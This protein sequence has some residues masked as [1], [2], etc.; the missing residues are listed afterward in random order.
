MTDVFGLRVNNANGGGQIDSS[1][2]YVNIHTLEEGVGR[3]Y[4]RS[5]EI[6]GLDTSIHDHCINAKPDVAYLVE[7]LSELIENPKSCLLYTS[8]SPRDRT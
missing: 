6:R 3:D 7:K 5:S 4:D 8:P 1:T 2:R